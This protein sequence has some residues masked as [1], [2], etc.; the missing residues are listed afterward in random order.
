MRRTIVRSAIASTAWSAT[1]DAPLAA[2]RQFDPLLWDFDAA[3][4]DARTAACRVGRLAAMG[5]AW[6]TRLLVIGDD[7]RRQIEQHELDELLLRSRGAARA[8]VREGR[9]RV[10]GVRDV[11]V[12][13]DDAT[14]LHVG[15]GRDRRV[16]REV[17]RNPRR[18]R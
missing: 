14:A 2:P 6:R 7:A 9:P 17:K 10:R 13:E 18:A 5:L 4:V 8:L 16:E 3:G 12:A 1:S 11:E 15:R